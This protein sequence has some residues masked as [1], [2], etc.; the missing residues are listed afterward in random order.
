MMTT[1]ETTVDSYGNWAVCKEGAGDI[2]A[3]LMTEDMANV[4]CKAMNTRVE[5]DKARIMKLY[6]T[7]GKGDLTQADFNE[8]FKE[9]DQ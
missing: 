9:T 3:D 2:I 4:V 1:F 5:A 7:W 8:A 6:Q